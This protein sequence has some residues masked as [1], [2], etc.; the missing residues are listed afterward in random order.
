MNSRAHSCNLQT[1]LDQVS[2][3]YHGTEMHHGITS[4]NNDQPICTCTWFLENMLGFM[5]SSMYI[6]SIII[7]RPTKQITAW[8]QHSTGILT[9]TTEN[10]PCRFLSMF[11]VQAITAWFS[12][13]GSPTSPSIEIPTNKQLTWQHSNMIYMNF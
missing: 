4:R 6:L 13:F 10:N 2:Y 9:Q 11:K 7:I 3:N 12:T 1:K 5:N 8:Y